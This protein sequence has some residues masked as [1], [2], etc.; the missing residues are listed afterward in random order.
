MGHD[1]LWTV[2]NNKFYLN[3]LDNIK[4]RHY[5]LSDF[6][7]IISHVILVNFKKDSFLFKNVIH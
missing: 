7:I 2:E 4:D 5:V 1:R 3:V 6:T